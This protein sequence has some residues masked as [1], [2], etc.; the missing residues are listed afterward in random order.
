MAKSKLLTK[1]DVQKIL[2]QT[3]VQGKRMIFKSPDLPV[4]ILENKDAVNDAEVHKKEG[5]LWHCLE[6]EVKFVYG[7]ELVDEW[8][9]KDM[10]GNGNPNE[11]RAK[12][13]SNGT[14]VVLKSGDWLWIPPGEPHQHSGTGKL[15]IIKIS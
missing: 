7:G 4:G 12:A 11:L 15:V 5:D 14:E 10:E 1:K 2:S 13:I 6:G 8:A 3:S 9:A